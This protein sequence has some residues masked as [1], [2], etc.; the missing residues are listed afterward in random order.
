MLP[1]WNFH[2]V[3]VGSIWIPIPTPTLMRIGRHGNPA[4][5]GRKPALREIE[6]RIGIESEV[7]DPS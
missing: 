1:L 2:E 5:S 3:E 7:T 4:L 6:V